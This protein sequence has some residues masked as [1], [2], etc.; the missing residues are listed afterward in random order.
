LR[1]ENVLHK[2]PGRYLISDFKCLDEHATINIE[3]FI[4][5]NRPN[6]RRSKCYKTYIFV[7]EKVFSI[8]QLEFNRPILAYDR[9]SKPIYLASPEIFL[10]EPDR[11]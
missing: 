5:D 7:R 9:I 1:N 2:H 6:A 10:A 4:K 11:A 8:M 3:L